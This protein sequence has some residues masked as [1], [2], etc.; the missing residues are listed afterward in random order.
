[1]PYELVANFKVLLYRYPYVLD[2]FFF[3]GTP[4]PTAGQPR[5]GDAETL[6]ILLYGNLVFHRFVSRRMQL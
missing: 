1:M 3:C 5:H 4:R 2:G 6:S